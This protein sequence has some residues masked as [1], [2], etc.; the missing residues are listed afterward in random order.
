MGWI[1]GVQKWS[2][3]ARMPIREQWK[4]H[5]VPVCAKQEPERDW[6]SAKQLCPTYVLK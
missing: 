1:E 3:Q 5:T 4:V 6:A 2:G